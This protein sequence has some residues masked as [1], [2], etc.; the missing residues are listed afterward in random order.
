MYLCNKKDKLKGQKL[1]FSY[2]YLLIITFSITSL[3]FLITYNLQNVNIDYLYFYLLDLVITYL[4]IKFYALGIYFLDK[5]IPIEQ[6]FIKRVTYQLTLHTLSVIIFNILMNEFFD[7]IFFNS[8]RL[9][10]SFNFYTQDTFVALVFVYFIHAIYFTLF[11]LFNKQN[12]ESLNLK[13]DAKIKVANG[14]N[15][16]TL[17]LYSVICVYY[18]FGITYVIDSNFKKYTSN[19]TLKEF[20]SMLDESFFRANRKI[21]VSRNIVDSYK[22]STNGK[23]EIILNENTM[24][25]FSEPIII[26][27]DK[28]SSFR[29]WLNKHL[30][31]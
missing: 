6:D 14:A 24:L 21:I 29:T 4:N 10:L 1:L 17:S 8:T 2:K 9:S 20:E 7:Y 22:G 5:K 19:L 28:A 11:L 15:F 3:N 26:S 12:V 13:L 23:V 16:K 27:R 31:V 30:I 25:E 18:E